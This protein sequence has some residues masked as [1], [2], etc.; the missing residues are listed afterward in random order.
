MT[1]TNL[2]EICFLMCVYF[3]LIHDFLSFFYVY[4]H[5]IIVLMASLLSRPS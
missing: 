4:F 5:Q 1:L 2:L 3:S